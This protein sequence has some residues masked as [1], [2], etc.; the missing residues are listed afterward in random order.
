MGRRRRQRPERHAQDL[1][2]DRA[3]F[4]L[5]R[6]RRSRP[7]SATPPPTSSTARSAPRASSASIRSP[8]ATSSGS[9]RCGGLIEARVRKKDLVAGRHRRRRQAG[10]T[11]RRPRRSRRARRTAAEP[12][13]ILSP[14]DPLVIQRK[15]L[16]LV[17]RLR[18]RL[19]GLCAEG[20][21]ALRLLRPAGARRRPHRRRPR[22]QDRPR[23][24]EAAHPAMDVDR[25][26]GERRDPSQRIE[27][28]LGRFERFQLAAIAVVPATFSTCS[29]ATAP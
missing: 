17:L 16:G 26:R 20:Q 1:R 27:D 2:P 19:R 6:R 4:R 8:M 14:F 24:R 18:P 11:G 3:P 5:G 25:R 23:R 21:A 15:R 10:R 28:E 7:R 12:V 29:R 13:H 9:R 22:P